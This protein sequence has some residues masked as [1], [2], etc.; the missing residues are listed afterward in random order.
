MII[1]T[2]IDIIELDRIARLIE[3][4]HFPEKVFS[5]EETESCRS[6][7][8]EGQRLV[9]RY[10][11]L[12]AAK[13]A[14]MKALGTGWTGGVTWVDISISHTDKGRPMVALS[15][16]TLEV[17]ES[18]GVKKVHVSISHCKTFAVAHAVL[19]GK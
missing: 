15:G 18:M 5:K 12:F 17:A 7:G 11:G 3:K 2:G 6:E 14:V 19:E 8:F 4:D 10:A 1:G 9:S 13:E 16:K